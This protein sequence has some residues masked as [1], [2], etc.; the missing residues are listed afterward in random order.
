MSLALRLLREKHLLV[1]QFSIFVIVGCTAALMHFLI[2]GLLVEL[3]VTGPVV[4]TMV[5]F[6][7]GTLVSYVLNRHFTFRSSRAHTSALPRYL[8]VA[9]IAFLLNA[10]LMDL[11]THRLGLFYLLAQALTSGIVLCW[12]FTGYRLWAF[13]KKEESHD[14]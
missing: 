14:A 6:V 13:A 12:T 11:F 2:L 5:G 10:G 3:S 9:G 8:A 1:R 4:G 7:A